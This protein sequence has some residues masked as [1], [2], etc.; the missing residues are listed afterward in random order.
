MRKC[1]IIVA[2]SRNFSDYLLLQTILDNY[3]VSNEN[4]TFISG[5]AKGADTMGEKY[6][7]ERDIPIIRCPANWKQ[8]H[9]GAGAKRNEEM[10]K[11][12]IQNDAHGIL[13]AFWDGKSSGT[14]HM[15]TIAEKYNLEVHIIKY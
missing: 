15:I 11:I 2:G 14:K 1:N 9:K 5:T 6:A 7:V 3:I 12:A 13:F 4:I 10:A 8:Y